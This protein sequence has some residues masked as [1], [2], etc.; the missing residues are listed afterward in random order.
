MF[1]KLYYFCQYCPQML[2]VF[3]QYTYLRERK[4]T[5]DQKILQNEEFYNL[6]SLTVITRIRKSKKKQPTHLIH[7]EEY[8]NTYKILVVQPEG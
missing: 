5:G 6:Y 7:M 4:L 2:I 3:V 1:V 8:R